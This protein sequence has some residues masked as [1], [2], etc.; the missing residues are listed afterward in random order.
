MKKI[1]ERSLRLESL[2]DRMLLAVTA[3]VESAEA[4]SA[5]PAQTG[6]EIV[7]DELTVTALNNAI[8]KA[9][10]GD[11]I[12]F[13]QG[14]TIAV[15]S[16]AIRIRK[17]LTIDGGG[18]VTIDGQGEAARLFNF[19]YGCTLTGLNLT[20]GYTTNGGFGGVGTVNAN[21]TVTLNNCNI[22]GNS[23]DNAGAYF[24]GAFQ[25]MGTL[26]LNNCSVYG[27]S[28][29][30]GGFAFLQGVNGPASG[31]ATLTADNCVFYG[32]TAKD[33]GAVIYNQGGSVTLTHCTVAGNSSVYGGAIA[34][35]SHLEVTANSAV[36]PSGTDYQ[37]SN[38]YK[39][40]LRTHVPDTK[41]IDSVVA[42]NYGSDSSTAD[43]H[44]LYNRVL[45][46][47][48]V[49]RW[50]FNR[51][52]DFWTKVSTSN[53][54]VGP[55]GDYFVQAPVF[56]AEGNLANADTLDL[57]INSE[58][59]AAYAGIG[60]GSAA[61]TGAGYSDASLVVTTL[62]DSIDSA[63]GAVSLREAIAYAAV[64]SFA[65]TPTITFADGLAGGTITLAYGALGITSDVNIVGDNIT[66]DADGTDRALY[67]RTVNYQAV[68]DGCFN[69][70]G[71]LETQ[72]SPHQFDDEYYVDVAID[73]LNFTG[74]AATCVV[75]AVGNPTGNSQSLSAEANILSRGTGGAGILANEN[76][77]LT[78]S[79]STISG[80]TF[81]VDATNRRAGGGGIAVLNNSSA[82]LTNVKV[83]DN[84][85]IQT[86]AYD[87]NNTLKGGGIY[88]GYR[89]TLNLSG[90]EVS[91]NA[92]TAA[93]YIDG[94]AY[95]YGHGFG[96]GICTEGI[97]TAISYSTV[98]DNAIVG[99]AYQ[100][101]GGGIYYYH[102]LTDSV[103]TGDD[104]YQSRFIKD[105]NSGDTEWQGFHYHPTAAM[106]AEN[107][108]ALIVDNT[109]I[110]GNSVGDHNVVNNGFCAGG[111]VY[112]SGLALMV[113]N[114][115]A[116]NS[117]D[118]G[119]AQANLTA[120]I[121]GG[122]VYN[123]S[124]KDALF[125]HK[126]EDPIYYNDTAADL[127]Y[128][129]IAGNSVGYVSY[130]GDDFGGGF[131][132]AAGVS[133]AFVGNILVNNV[134]VNSTT[135]A[136]AAND[137]AK[138]GSSF[139][140]TSSVYAESGVKGSGF[141]F[142]GGVSLS[143][144]APLFVDADA[145]DYRLVSNA[146]AVDALAASAPAPELTFDYDVR[147]VPYVRVYNGV[148]D[149]G[150]Y[151]FQNETA[152]TPTF[153]VTITDYVGD[154]DG[155]AHTVSIGGLEDGDTVLYS[156]DGT[157]YSVEEI[158]YT[159]AG[160][161]TVYVKVQRA[162]Y[163]D[164]LG[165]G[166]VVINEAAPAEQLAAPVISTGNRGIYVSYGANR[167]LIQWGA[168]ANA[169]GYEVGYTVGGSSWE[170]VTVTDPSAVITGLAYGTDVTYQVRALGDGV[171]Y[172]DSEWSASKTFNVC[173][174]DINNDG[175]ISGRDRNLL[176]NSWL[177][178]EGD[179]E[180]QYYADV[181]GDGDVSGAD[182]NFVSNNWL[183]EAGDDDL[184]YPRALAADAV[185]AAYEAGDLDVDFDVF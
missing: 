112:T 9:K 176:A 8:S 99:A 135:G 6:A 75:D 120:K 108:Y 36:D 138:A 180:Y 54:I 159:E 69:V 52:D 56:D 96:G 15:G 58:S 78:L 51:K 179:D 33:F 29:Y 162:G 87:I 39:W 169:S 183:G 32:N 13:S 174:M 102:A 170:T 145:G 95:G 3:G 125:G 160:T 72:L 149:I 146:A 103:L 98:S 79:N 41:I 132:D 123:E 17:D 113:N 88:I 119:D 101:Y 89:S 77:N 171:S 65:E 116:D 165:S 181:N 134:S 166:S 167:H 57:T 136:K 43:F 127:Y 59:L 158:A 23:T 46:G 156:A 38:P 106:L 107:P 48:G 4:A 151:E 31:R 131:Y 10:A 74:G 47:N 45:H 2:E 63:D 154:Y 185:F 114:L 150:C 21:T 28:A 163:Q 93:S 153:E 141:V 118:A 164:F 12:T 130:N 155:A 71:D 110:T 70:I 5:A 61:Y 177:S 60:A 55:K 24:G 90:S 184:T 42:Y 172:A 44:D 139:T 140:L 25:V 157:S 68:F 104:D 27:N 182:R 49:Q 142:D 129:T 50:A 148:Q 144:S 92:L 117:L 80:N 84:T 37:P 152:P 16:T 86:G 100:Q 14:G 20:G 81:Y 53:S 73:G 133:S 76:V 26:A 126:G 94:G 147:N 64:G 67:M 121:H 1:R 128:C 40:N 143:D 66:I 122:G 83:L 22:Y 11:V 35:V 173:P 161:Y 175:D 97:G 115:I 109:V 7:V 111:G 124:V 178:E 168:V 18:R 82:V 19:S 137:I 62:E 105:Y 34:N 85:V 91:G 30:Y